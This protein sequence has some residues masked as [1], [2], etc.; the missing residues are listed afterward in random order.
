MKLNTPSQI[1][2]NLHNFSYLLLKLALF[3][4]VFIYQHSVHLAGA[5]VFA[6]HILEIEKMSQRR[7][8]NGYKGKERPGLSPMSFAHAETLADR[9]WE[10]LQE[11]PEKYYG[12]VHL[13]VSTCASDF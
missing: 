9:P 12:R 3:L 1:N 5:L 2:L 7:R 6:G 8:L 10:E 4:P 13:A 11:R